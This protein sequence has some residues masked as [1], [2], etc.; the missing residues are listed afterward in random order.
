MTYHFIF[1]PNALSPYASLPL[2]NNENQIQ[3]QEIVGTPL[4]DSNL[5]IEQENIALPVINHV[6]ANLNQLSQQYPDF[7]NW[8]EQ[9]VFTG[10]YNK[11]RSILLEWR[12]GKIA[13]L[14]ILK[15]EIEEKK[16]CCLRIMPEF[17]NKGIG[18]KLFQRSFAELGTEKP[19]L[20]VSEQK[21][22]E[23]EKIFNYFGF[24]QTEK[25][26]DLYKQNTIEIS[27]N[28]YLK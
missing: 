7:E 21:L 16:L 15:N 5:I 14:A 20:S 18:I 24:V 22:S 13:G 11:T 28:G 4:I 3:R 8:L 25:Y 1:A 6:F 27:Y 9:K 19:L 12:D 17:Q 2:F 10:L 26:F 23:F